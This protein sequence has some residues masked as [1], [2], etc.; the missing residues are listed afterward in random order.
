M[1]KTVIDQIF[2][3]FSKQN[4]TP[5]TELNYTN[6]YTLLV[7]V[8]LSAQTTDIGVNK[9]TKILFKLIQTPEDMVKLGEDKLRKHIKTIGLC[10]TKSKNIIN[11]SKILIEN[12]NSQIPSTLEDLIHLPGIGTKTARVILNTA[13]NQPEIAVDTHVLRT[14]TRIGISNKKSTASVER[15]LNQIIPTPWKKHAHHWLVLHGRYICKARSPLCNKCFISDLCDYFQNHRK[16]N[17]P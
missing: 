17:I 7:A 12:Y 15:D 3:R 8:M 1:D 14:S 16:K 5:K 6:H 2:Q 10:N 4:P 11:T 13:F 9:A